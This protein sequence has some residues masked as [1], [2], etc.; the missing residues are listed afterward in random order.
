MM[1]RA[2]QGVD[3]LAQVTVTLPYGRTKQLSDLVNG[4]AK[5]VERLQAEEH[6]SLDDPLVWGADDYVGALH[7]RD[8][9]VT[10]VD[11]SPPEIHDLALVRVASVDGAF[12][13]FTEPDLRRI[14]DRFSGEEHSESEWWWRRLP[15]T[16]PVR[17]ELE[18]IAGRDRG[19][20]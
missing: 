19:T 5:H 12:M 11:Q 14:I 16:G 4:W 7:L 18:Q 20:S 17:E 15:K 6:S 3:P 2:E 1:S 10:G 9:V 13:S 8:L